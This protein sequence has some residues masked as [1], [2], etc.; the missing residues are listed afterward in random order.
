M[1]LCHDQS[2]LEIPFFYRLRVKAL[3]PVDPGDHIEGRHLVSVSH[4]LLRTRRGDEAERLFLVRAGR[5]EGFLLWDV[6]NALISWVRICAMKRNKCMQG[7]RRIRNKCRIP[8][9]QRLVERGSFGVRLV[10]MEN[11]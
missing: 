11:Y 7:Q 5:P 1:A 10:I 2:S 8:K 9:D 6:N 4:E 3:G